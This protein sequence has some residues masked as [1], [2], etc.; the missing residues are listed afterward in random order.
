MHEIADEYGIEE[1]HQLA[2]ETYRRPPKKRAPIRSP[3]L[4]PEMAQEIREYAAE[5][6]DAHHQDIA[7]KY[8]V[9]HGRV[10]QALNREI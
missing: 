4:T 8:G 3:K 6:P 1:L 10:S 9:N 5:H 2:D 7:E